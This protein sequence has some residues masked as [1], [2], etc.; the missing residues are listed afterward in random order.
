MKYERIKKLRE[1]KS[2]T[3]EEVSN[4]ISVSKRIYNNYETG[5]QRL[6]LK[7][8]AA[9]ADYYDVSADYIVNLTDEKT[10]HKRSKKPRL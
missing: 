10:P 5:K 9:L 4:A 2:L 6:P 3:Q 8:L 1:E 7:I